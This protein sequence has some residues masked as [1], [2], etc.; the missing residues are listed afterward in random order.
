MDKWRKLRHYNPNISYFVHPDDMNFT[1][2]FPYRFDEFYRMVTGGREPPAG[3]RLAARQSVIG[4][5]TINLSGLSQGNLGGGS[6]VSTSPQTG[7]EVV[8]ARNAKRKALD[9]FAR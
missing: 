6:F 4:N 8:K 2:R 5:N 1:H 7:P 9:E 3:L